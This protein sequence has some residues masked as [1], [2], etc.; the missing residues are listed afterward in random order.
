MEQPG[1][2]M[3]ILEAVQAAYYEYLREV[4]RIGA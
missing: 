2:S 1:T 3:A 4:N